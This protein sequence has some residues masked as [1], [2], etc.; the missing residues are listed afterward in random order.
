MQLPSLFDESDQDEEKPF[1][2]MNERRTGFDDN[3]QDDEKSQFYQFILSKTEA[4]T[5]R[6]QELYEHAYSLLSE[7]FYV[8]FTSLRI[9]NTM[10]MLKKG[11]DF[12]RKSI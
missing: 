12:S 5:S 10:L 2:L 4:E 3:N 8:N 1:R 6:F 9:E 7:D 11:I